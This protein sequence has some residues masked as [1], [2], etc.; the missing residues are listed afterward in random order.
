MASATVTDGLFAFVSPPVAV[1]FKYFPY[2][3]QNLI[4]RVRAS[5][6]DATIYRFAPS[7]SISARLSG[8]LRSDTRTLAGWNITAINHQERLYTSKPMFEDM[9]SSNPFY[10]VLTCTPCRSRVPHAWV[11]VSAS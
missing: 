11:R 10:A 5:G 8:L 1:G 3:C 7:S 2:D 4:V 6:D 9:G